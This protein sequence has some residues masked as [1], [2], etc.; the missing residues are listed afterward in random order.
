MTTRTDTKGCR[1]LEQGEEIERL[2]EI[3][4]RESKER[5]RDRLISS[6]VYVLLSVCFAAA[7]CWLLLVDAACVLAGVLR[8]H[9]D[10]GVRVRMRVRLVLNF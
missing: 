2:R 7:N 4:P 8:L 5:H 6:C 9:L 1:E 3:E 10:S